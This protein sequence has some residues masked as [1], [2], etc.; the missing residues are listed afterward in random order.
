[1]EDPLYLTLKFTAETKPRHCGAGKEYMLEE[2]PAM[3]GRTQ[4]LNPNQKSV[5]TPDGVPAMRGKYRQGLNPNRKA[6]CN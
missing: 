1:M 3:R 2:D 5:C 4:G 6:I